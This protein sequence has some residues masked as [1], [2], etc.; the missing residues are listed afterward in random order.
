[1]MLR[2]LIESHP[3]KNEMD[4]TQ[5]DLDQICNLILGGKPENEDR[6]FLYEI[7]SNS[8]NGIDVDKIDY[9]LRDSS[10]LN[11]KHCS[12]NP[13][14]LI[15]QARVVNGEICYPEKH[16]YIVKQL[17]DSRYNLYRDCY[18]HRVTQMHECLILDI[19]E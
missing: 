2:Y 19:L 12:F 16:E 13:W 10:K 4:I 6:R 3:K 15:K 7:V 14:I 18:Y 9:L 5:A 17:F 1:M 11:V 8:R